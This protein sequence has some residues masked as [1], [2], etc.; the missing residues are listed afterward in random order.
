MAATTETADYVGRLL[1]NDTPGVTD[2]V[3]D[4]LGR[5]IDSGDVDYLGRDLQTP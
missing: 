4:Y 2:P 1:D 3:T 5:E